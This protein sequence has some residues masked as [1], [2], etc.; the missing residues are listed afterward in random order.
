MTS[1]DQ[2]LLQACTKALLIPIDDDSAF[3]SYVFSCIQQKVVPQL[4]DSITLDQVENRAQRD[5]VFFSEIATKLASMPTGSYFLVQRP[6]LTEP[7][8]VFMS[9]GAGQLFQGLPCYTQMPSPENIQNDYYAVVI[10]SSRKSLACK[11]QT[12]FGLKAIIQHQLVKGMTF[13]N[14]SIPSMKLTAEK[15]IIQSIDQKCGILRL[16]L[17]ISG[18]R[19]LVVTNMPAHEFA[20]YAHLEEKT[21]IPANGDLFFTSQ[22]AD[23][24]FGIQ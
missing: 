8:S 10:K 4:V 1:F 11:M 7:Y 5:R 3:I 15:A 22:P 19:N 2:G 13:K 16:C 9:D 14:V 21:L 6:Y 17:K 24:R 12:Q 20:M 23:M 18:Q